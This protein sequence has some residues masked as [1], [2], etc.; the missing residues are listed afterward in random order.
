MDLNTKYIEGRGK[1]IFFF[2]NGRKNCMI[3]D[4]TLV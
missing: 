2:L 3:F 1:A 4:K